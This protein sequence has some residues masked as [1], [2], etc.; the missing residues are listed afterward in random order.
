MAEPKLAPPGA[1][2]P[3]LVRMVIKHWALPKAFKRSWEDANHY[4]Q[5][6]LNV[7]SELAASAPADLRGERILVDPIRGLEDSSR[8]WSIQ[9]TLE[10]LCIVGDEIGKGIILLSQGK[11]PEKVADTAAVKPFGV[12]SFDQTW[13]YFQSMKN[14]HIKEINAQVVDRKST[15][16]LSHPWFGPFTCHQ[17]NWMLGV[18]AGIHR[19][20]IMQILKK[21][22]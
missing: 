3:F 1:G 18:H 2:I 13:Q 9:M 4:Y 16:T 7:I 12:Q 17:W 5:R 20:Q 11:R 19:T 22:S 6:Q 21:I 8:F 10:H 14:D 15:H